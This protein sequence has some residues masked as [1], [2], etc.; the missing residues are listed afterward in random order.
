MRYV[1]GMATNPD[2]MLLTVE[3]F[4][5]IDF[6]LEKKAELSNG[7]IRMMA[8]G[9]V[10]HNQIQGNI[11]ALLHARLRGSGCQPFGSDMGVRVHELSFRYPD[12]S[13]FCGRDNEADDKRRELDDPRMVVEVLSPS[14]RDE[15]LA[16]KLPEYKAIASMQTILYIDPDTGGMRLLQRTGPAAWN[17][18]ELAVGEPVPLPE[19]DLTLAYDDIFARG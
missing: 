15:D 14:T 6:G 8:G 12:V 19:F 13:V 1:G 9:T 11:F 7:I 5:R 10:R 18:A 17:D 16:V 2:P 4:L 3:E